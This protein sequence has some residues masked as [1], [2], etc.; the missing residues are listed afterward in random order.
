MHRIAGFEFRS[1]AWLESAPRPLLLISANELKQR[2]IDL[3]RVTE[4][5][6]VLT[7]L[8]HF[9][10]CVRTVNKERDLLSRVLRATR[11][12]VRA[13]RIHTIDAFERELGSEILTCTQRRSS[14]ATTRPDT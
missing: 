3:L 9:E 4:A 1:V 13:I 12:L 11:S 14:H 10:L 8:D 2:F 7:V 6:E 5:Q